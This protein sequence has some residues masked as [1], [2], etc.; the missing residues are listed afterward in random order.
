MDVEVRHEEGG[1]ARVAARGVEDLARLS[2]TVAADAP[3]DAV[4][5]ALRDAGAGHLDAGGEHAWLRLSWLRAQGPDAPGWLEGFAGMVSYA[6]SRGWT[7]EDG[8]LV[9]AHVERA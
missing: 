1:G 4:D 2:A 3:A 5:G 7:S 6:T 8:T 9:R